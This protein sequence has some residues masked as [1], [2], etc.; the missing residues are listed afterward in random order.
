MSLPNYQLD[1]PEPRQSK[2]DVWSDI[3]DLAENIALYVRA[4]KPDVRWIDVVSY[5]V[6]ELNEKIRMLKEGIA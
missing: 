5:E 4:N 6:E 2:S 1:P 3:A